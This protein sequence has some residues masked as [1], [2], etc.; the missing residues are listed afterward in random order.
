MKNAQ[1]N[2]SPSIGSTT[3]GQPPDAFSEVDLLLFRVTYEGDPRNGRI[4]YRENVARLLPGESELSMEGHARWLQHIHPDDRSVYQVEI[5]EN[6]RRKRP[7]HLDYRLVRADGTTIHVQ[8]VGQFRFD[9][10]LHVTGIVGYVTPALG[11]LERCELERIKSYC[12]GISEC[13]LA[14]NSSRSLSQVHQTIT[15]Q[16][17]LVIGAHQ[18]VT[19]LTTGPDLAQAVNALSLSDKYAAWRSYDKIPD[20]SGIYA[21]I[22]ESNITARMTQ[23]ELE[24][25]P[26][27]RGFGNERHAHPPMRG[28]LAAPLVGSDGQNLGLIELSDKFFG[29]FDETDEA[30]LVQLAKMA[31]VAIENARLHEQIEEAR[32]NL[33]LNVRVRTAELSA[34]N[35]KLQHEMEVRQRADRRLATQY[36]IVR[37]LAEAPNLGAAI[38]QILEAVCRILGWE[39]GVFWRL[40]EGGKYLRCAE[41]WHSS[42]AQFEAFEAASRERV[43]ELGVGLPGRVWQSREPAWIS[44]V[45]R[46]RNFPRARIAAQ[47][48]LHGAFAFPLQWSDQVIGVLEFFTHEIRE[49]DGDLLPIFRSLGSQIGHF[50]LR[51]QADEALAEAKVAADQANRAKSM[52]LAAMSHEIRTP[53]NGIVGMA[54]LTLASDLNSEQREYLEMVKTSA[55]HLLAVIN[56]ILDFSK[57]EAG[58][59]ELEQLDFQLRDL[60]DSSLATVA[61]KAHQKGLELVG[62]VPPHV[63]DDLVGDPNRLRQVLI[64]LVSNAVKFT[65]NGEVVL[66]LDCGPPANDACVLQVSVRDTGIGIPRDKQGLLF[67][68]FSQVDNATTRKFGGTGLG[69]AISSQI[70][71]LMGGRIEVDSEPGSGSVFRFAVPMGIS[72]A[73]RT[74]H[75]SD[76]DTEPTSVQ[77]R[78]VLVVDDNESN[79]NMLCELIADRKMAPIA[80]SDG[81]AALAELEKAV[82]ERTPFAL[83]LIDGGLRG[84]DGFAVVARVAQVAQGK[85]PVVMMLS[86]PNRNAEVNRCREMGIA[87][88]VAK[89][90]RRGELLRAIHSA[91]TPRVVS[92]GPDQSVKRTSIERCTRSLRILLT[93]DNAVNQRLAI[94]LLEKRGHSTVAAQ[95]G[96]EAIAALD[97]EPFDVVLMDVEMPDVDGYAATTAIRRAEMN[98]GRHIPIVAMTAHALH[99]DRE[100]C[101][102]AGMDAFISKPLRAHELFDVVE[103]MAGLKPAAARDVR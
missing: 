49:P 64:N 8:D 25:H 69:L 97:R 39:M 89:P 66:R 73:K 86:S 61:L 103:R 62:H 100:L 65:S 46:D 32:N 15:D 77:A 84:A 13:T 102:R 36:E 1:R 72:A 83:V 23:R 51:T 11:A 45:I 50:V 29:E 16:A 90:V 3:L 99:E 37:I 68:S 53:L 42:A 4:A 55:D 52:F 41:L 95:N 30:I 85:M 59:L 28:W 31:A 21:M 2:V 40:D 92:A 33:E 94:R 67:K 58:K 35:M 63:P 57:V 43:F 14:L 6:L 48:G 101:L 60:I 24:R 20:G 76:S 34:A 19:S 91:L 78:R 17:R 87:D 74:A 47:S 79:R 18:S 44:D 26:R 98:T 54:E 22:C 93:E 56:D 10:Q 80:V 9:E 27:W 81:D 5:A 12:Q 82:A 96:R 7:F 75:E 70:V 38:P 71:Q 88:Y